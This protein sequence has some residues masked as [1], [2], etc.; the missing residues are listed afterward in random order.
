MTAKH[1]PTGCPP[2][3][4]VYGSQQVATNATELHKMS[5][6]WCSSIEAFPCADHF[7]IGHSNKEGR[8]LCRAE[9][10]KRTEQKAAD[11]NWDRGRWAKSRRA[12]RS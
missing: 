12:G 11:R 8:E 1:G 4:L 10:E 2:G 5:S 7:H 3:H 9:S 6:P